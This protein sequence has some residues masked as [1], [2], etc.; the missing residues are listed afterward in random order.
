MNFSAMNH[1]VHLTCMVNLWYKAHF[2][3]LCSY[4]RLAFC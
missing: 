4:L 2:K 3:H 1:T